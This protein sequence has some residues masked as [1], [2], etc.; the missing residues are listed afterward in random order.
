MFQ[1]SFTRRMHEWLD[2]GYGSCLLRESKHALI[3]ADALRFFDGDRCALGDFAVM[4]NHVHLLVT[5][6]ANWPLQ[7][8]LHSWKQ[9][10]ARE[11]NKLLEREGALWLD[12]SFDHVV[13][14][15]EQLSFFRQ[16]IR[17]NPVKAK[18]PQ[19]EFLLGCGSDAESGES[20]TAL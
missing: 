7:A 13:R 11:I 4:P 20:G 14:S 15:S 8:L 1:Q 3:V 2:A 18:L 12:E 6:Y 19:G 10:T 5:P 16:Y 17:E 9:F